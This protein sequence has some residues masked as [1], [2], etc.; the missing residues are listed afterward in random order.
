MRKITVSK[1]RYPWNQCPWHSRRCGWFA[2]WCQPVL[3]S[4]YTSLLHIVLL[5]G[6]TRKTCR[7]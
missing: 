7:L 6:K 1:S 4:A 3:P 5:C 2:S